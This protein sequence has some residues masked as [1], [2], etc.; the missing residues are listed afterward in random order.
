[1]TLTLF[2]GLMIATQP[3]LSRDTL[4][5]FRVDTTDK[6]HFQVGQTLGNAVKQQFPNIEARYDAYLNTI[7]TQAQFAEAER[8]RVAE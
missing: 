8:R 7:M 4:P 5:I 3:A 2:I 1:M 6:T